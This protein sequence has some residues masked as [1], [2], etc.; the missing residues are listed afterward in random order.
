MYLFVHLRLEL[1]APTDD[2][3][4]LCAHIADI[5]VRKDLQEC[6]IL[7]HPGGAKIGLEI[8]AGFKRSQFGHQ[9]CGV[10]S[11]FDRS[12]FLGFLFSLCSRPRSSSGTMLGKPSR[13]WKWRS[14][15]PRPLAQGEAGKGGKEME[16]D[17]KS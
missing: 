6:Q 13:R 12:S 5:L 1:P 9:N 8:L 11:K 7:G 10:R 3:R 14:V 16:R 15:L 17:G 4:Y 2:I